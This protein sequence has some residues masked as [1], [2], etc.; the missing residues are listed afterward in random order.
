M[1]LK[2]GTA[3][4]GAASLNVD[5]LGALSIL[6]RALATPATGDIPANTPTELC[7]DPTAAN[8]VIMGGG[9]GSI[10]GTLSTADLVPYVSASQTLSSDSAFGF[11]PTTKHV[12]AGAAAG[13]AGSISIGQV[14][15]APGIWVGAN[16]TTPSASNYTLYESG[17][18]FINEPTGGTDIIFRVANADVLRTR[19]GTGAIQFISAAESTCD[20]GNR[21]KFVYVAGGAGVADTVRM[22][23]KNAA[24]VYSFEAVATWP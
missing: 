23:G 5:T 3:N 22:C 8:W 10:G 21:G 6:T 18:L 2:P 7:L 9:G 11:N 14:S 12:R 1:V 15:S 17:A 16:T 20:V 13:S 4:T 19:G 24:D